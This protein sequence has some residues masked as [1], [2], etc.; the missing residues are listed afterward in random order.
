MG[1]GQLASGLISGFM[2]GQSESKAASAAARAQERQT[3]KAIAFQKEQAE[4]ARGLLDPYVQAGYAALGTPTKMLQGGGG[5][6]ASGFG[7]DPRNMPPLPVPPKPTYTPIKRKVGGRGGGRGSAIKRGQ[8][9][10]ALK[11]QYEKDLK[12]WEKNYGEAQKWNESREER[13][14][15]WDAE[16]KAIAKLSGGSAP[17]AQTPAPAPVEADGGLIAEPAP[18]P[19]PAP[20]Q[21]QGGADFGGLLTALAMRQQE[22]QGADIQMGRNPME[23]QNIGAGGLLAGMPD[24]RFSAPTGQAMQAQYSPQS[25]TFV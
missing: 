4:I 14:K 19:T 17:V 2:G 1:L 8:K 11:K 6:G 22:P 21:Q 7:G 24:P 13:I 23:F 12:A 5:G 20:A 25:W 3:D 10:R 15:K 9:N 18:K 16:Q